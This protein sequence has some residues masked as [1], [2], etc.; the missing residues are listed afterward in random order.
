MTLS[1]AAEAAV[2]TGL[3]PST[4]ATLLA[5]KQALEQ[6]QGS[7]LAAL[8]VY[9]SAVRGGYEPGT[10]DIDVIVVL[11]DTGLDK[12]KVLSEPLLLA[13]YT[14][15]VEA[16]IL[17]CLNI[18]AASD[19]FPL[20]YEDVRQKNVLLSGADL[21]TDLQIQDEHC[22]L[23]VEQELREARIRMRRAVV[24]A[25]GS[26]AGVAGVVARKV[27]QVRSPLHALLRLKGIRCDDG[28]PAVLDAVGRAYGIDTSPLLRVA[29][30]PEAAHAALRALLDAAIADVDGLPTGGAA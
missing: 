13:R 22:R 26:D 29:A 6:G 1:S 28:L 7:N 24:D 30:A 17:K 2:L 11:H 15:R 10:S 9:G 5:L 8:V 4:H 19:V 23:R 12:L 16:M 20:L 27:K 14:G 25:L 21:F 3:P 18:A